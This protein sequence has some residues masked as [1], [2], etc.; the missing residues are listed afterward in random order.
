MSCLVVD[1]LNAVGYL[2]LG[3]FRI[4]GSAAGGMLLEVGFN[5]AEAPYADSGT[6]A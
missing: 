5:A 6:C 1:L 2:L 3:L 4:G